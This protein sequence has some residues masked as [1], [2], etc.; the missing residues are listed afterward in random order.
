MRVRYFRN[1]LFALAAFLW[2]P[3]SA[4]CAL[5]TVPGF[6]FLRCA[7]EATESHNPS[8]DCSNCC[9]V[10]KSQYRAESFRLTAPAPELLPLIVVSVLPAV[11][12]LPAQI[13]LGVLTAAPPELP[14]SCHFLLR[15]ALPPRAP[16][17]VS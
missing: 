16:S 17:F 13:S 9:A 14:A 1:I 4:H 11:H 6:Q 2:L 8:K 7:P 15:T 5:E 10:E 3:V 12:V